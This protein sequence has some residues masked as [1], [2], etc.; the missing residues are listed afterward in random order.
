MDSVW[1][2]TRYSAGEVDVDKGFE[3][4]P[5]NRYDLEIIE[6]APGVSKNGFNMATLALR[7][8]NSLTHAGR[9]VKFQ[10]VTFLPSEN[11]GAFIALKFLKAI[12][13]PY[14][15]DFDIVPSRWVNKKFNASV[16][17]ETYEGKNGDT[18]EKNTVEFA[19]ATP[20]NGPEETFAPAA[21][22]EPEIPF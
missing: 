13:E 6:V 22:S 16:G 15:G 9:M 11:P 3:V 21:D 17:I 20:Y 7:V 14:K 10:R 19:T 12:G 5:R 1:S 8:C 2:S 4:L 18:R